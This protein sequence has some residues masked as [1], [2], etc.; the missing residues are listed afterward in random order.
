ML[1]RIFAAALFALLM[2]TA[3]AHASPI[4]LEDLSLNFGGGYTI[5]GGMYFQLGM[6]PA[7]TFTFS[8]NGTPLDLSSSFGSDPGHFFFDTSPPPLPLPPGFLPFEFDLARIDGI[9][10]LFPP[11]TSFSD[12][13]LN[14]VPAVSGS[15]S[16]DTINFGAGAVSCAA[17]TP[18]PAALPL[19]GSGVI[20]LAGF[21]VR[22]RGK[23]SLNNMS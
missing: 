12:F 5:N 9:G 2:T 3:P 15:V 20:A 6:N 11:P 18:L 23:V 7:P 10:P 22:R 8:F 21:A 14:D 19:F 17:P 13:A 4:Y 1:T 16:G